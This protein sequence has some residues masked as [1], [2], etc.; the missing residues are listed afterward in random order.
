[1]QISG[2]LNS[3]ASAS[4]GAL[5]LLHLREVFDAEQRMA[6]AS[7][8]LVRLLTENESW[9]WAE[10]RHGGRPITT[11]WLARTLKRYKIGPRKGRHANEYWAEDFADAFNRYLSPLEAPDFKVP[12]L[13]TTQKYAVISVR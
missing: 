11:H 12:H 6:L 2:E 10:W 8:E 13:H 7:T 9:P 4:T 3:D 5:L 1:M